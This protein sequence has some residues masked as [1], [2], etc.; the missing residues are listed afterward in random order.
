MNHPMSNQDVNHH[1]HLYPD[2]DASVA[3]LKQGDGS[4]VEP[5]I[6]YLER[7]PYTYGSGYLKEKIWRYLLRV[8]L[9][10]KQKERLREIA[11]HYIK[12][13]LSREFFPMCRFVN[14]IATDEFKQQVLTLEATGDVRVQQRAYLLDAH[15][16]GPQQAAEARQLSHWQRRGYRSSRL[17]PGDI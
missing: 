4:H 14:G 13:R 16:K 17:H 3:A 1:Q 5:V 8:T 15:F 6:Y 10:N 11:I 12:T 7:D 2:I 9:T